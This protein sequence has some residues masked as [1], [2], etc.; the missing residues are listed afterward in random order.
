MAAPA[1]ELAREPT[2]RGEAH[3]CGEAHAEESGEARA[4]A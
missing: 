4:E 1:F 3:E 2:G